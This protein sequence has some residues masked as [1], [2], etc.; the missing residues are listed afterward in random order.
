MR[1]ICG[2]PETEMGLNEFSNGGGADAFLEVETCI[3]VEKMRLYDQEY[4]TAVTLRLRN[5]KEL[6]V[7]LG[8]RSDIDVLRS[9]KW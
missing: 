2:F 9:L 5:K 1:S 3:I 4:W 8:K 7:T 6:M